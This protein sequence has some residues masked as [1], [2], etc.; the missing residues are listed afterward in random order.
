MIQSANRGFAGGG[1]KKKA[2]D[3]KETDFDIV[4]VGKWIKK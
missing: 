4:F 3:P 2:M 1:P